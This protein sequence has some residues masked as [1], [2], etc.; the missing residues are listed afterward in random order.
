MTQKFY[1]ITRKDDKTL[2]ING[3]E[4]KYFLSDPSVIGLS[5]TKFLPSHNETVEV[6]NAPLKREVVD[7]LM[8]ENP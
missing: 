7:F 8:G 4:H 2:L 5:L 1:N 3:Q 6:K